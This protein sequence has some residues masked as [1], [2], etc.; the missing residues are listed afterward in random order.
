MYH[1]LVATVFVLAGIYNLLKVLQQLGER[2]SDIPRGDFGFELF[3]VIRREAGW[4]GLSR[5]Y[6]LISAGVLA[7]CAPA[8]AQFWVG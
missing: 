8:L 3:G 5:T 1:S 4:W 2:T 7:S 6:G